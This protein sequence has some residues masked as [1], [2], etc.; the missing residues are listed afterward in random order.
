MNW[1]QNDNKNQKWVE[2]ENTVKSLNSELMELARFY[3]E[4]DNIVSLHKDGGLLSTATLNI[5]KACL[6]VVDSTCVV[7]AIMRSII[8]QQSIYIEAKIPS[9]AKHTVDNE[10]NQI[11]DSD[12]LIEKDNSLANMSRQKSYTALMLI[13]AAA[14]NIRNSMKT[15]NSI[16]KKDDC[17]K[18]EKRKAVKRNEFL[19]SKHT[20]RR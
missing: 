1:V 7:M 10:V 2:L 8:N 18:D 16:R 11:V 13:E 17:N 5:S 3:F 12:L 9:V 15:D 4:N 14:S 19:K 6:E 20:Y